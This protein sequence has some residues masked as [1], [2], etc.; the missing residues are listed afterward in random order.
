MQIFFVA[1]FPVAE[2]D[3]D[4]SS[5]LLS[6]ILFLKII[7][8]LKFSSKKVTAVINMSQWAQEDVGIILVFQSG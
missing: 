1:L 8:K 2:L 3:T 6:F 4:M 5:C 7:V